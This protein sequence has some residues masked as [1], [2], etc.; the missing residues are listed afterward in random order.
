MF[1]LSDNMRKIIQRKTGLAPEKLSELTLDQEIE[2]VK[3]IKKAAPFFSKKI[4]YRKMG[5]GNPLLARKR[6]R[7]MDYVDMR[8]EKIS[9]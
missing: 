7:T 2:L 9:K 5:R 4:D 1:K 6:Y 3:K 8:I